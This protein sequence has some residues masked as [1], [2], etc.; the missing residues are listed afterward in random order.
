M[1][2]KSNKKGSL[3]NSMNV[4]L[5]KK[6]LPAAPSCFECVKDYGIIDDTEDV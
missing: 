4:K 5:K 1:K 6:E 3:E 2:N